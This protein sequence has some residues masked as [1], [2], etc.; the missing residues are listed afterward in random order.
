[1]NENEEY[2]KY[3][4]AHE[5]KSYQ[6]RQFKVWGLEA[7]EEQF[8]NR[9][10]TGR[11]QRTPETMSFIA[12]LKGIREEAWMSLESDNHKILYDEMLEQASMIW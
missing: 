6:I 4:E 11:L 9:I 2:Y 7:L 1:M 12:M 3:P 5:L 8:W 10:E